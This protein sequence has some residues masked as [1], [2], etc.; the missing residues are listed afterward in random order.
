[1]RPGRSGARRCWA[2][3]LDGLGPAAGGRGLAVAD[4]PNF[5]A[6]KNV[7]ILR[8]LAAI[9]NMAGQNALGGHAMD[10][11]AAR[12]VEGFVGRVLHIPVHALV[13]IAQ[14]VV[15]G[16]P[17]GA[18]EEERLAELGA[19]FGGNH[20]ALLGARGRGAGLEFGAGD[21]PQIS[22]RRVGQRGRLQVAPGEKP[23]ARRWTLEPS[24]ALGIRLRLWSRPKASRAPGVAAP[25]GRQR[26]FGG[27]RKSMITDP[28]GYSDSSRS[29][30]Q[31]SS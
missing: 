1:M 15:G 19:G 22:P 23:R 18:L 6:A 26:L 4:R 17:L 9:N 24:M 29:C 16:A 2:P 12:L 28:I 10:P 30:R 14:Q 21:D 5:F 31:K 25:S 13:G 8:T 3:G 20:H 27:S 7:R 11:A